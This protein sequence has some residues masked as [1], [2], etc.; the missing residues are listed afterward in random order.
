M[1]GALASDSPSGTVLV[2]SGLV[3]KP[4]LWGRNLNEPHPEKRWLLGITCFFP[5]TKSSLVTNQGRPFPPKP[6]VHRHSRPALQGRQ[7]PA[8]RPRGLASKRLPYLFPGS[9]GGWACWPDIYAVI[10]WLFVKHASLIPL[11]DACRS[12]S[13]VAAWKR[14]RERG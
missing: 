4:Q 8:I 9:G 1:E 11:S 6:G 14:E 10:S 5:S 7:S 3:L 2:H 12:V 13:S